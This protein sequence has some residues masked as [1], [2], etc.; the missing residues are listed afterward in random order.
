MSQH[1]SRLL[2]FALLG[3]LVSF[4]LSWPHPAHPGTVSAPDTPPSVRSRQSAVLH[5]YG[6]LPLS[7]ES[8]QGQTDHRV[9]FLARSS[10]S[11]LYLTPTEAFFTLTDRSQMIRAH[12]TKSGQSNRRKQTASASPASVCMQLVGADPAAVA[13]AEKPLVGTVNYFIGR[14]PRNWHSDVPTCAR[15]RFQQVY[16][17]VDVVYYGDR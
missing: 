9:R 2:G 16:P 4:G 12:G 8:N 11:T 7:F 3:A 15:A 1:S 5:A 14:D 17:G 13:A 10:D 6:Q